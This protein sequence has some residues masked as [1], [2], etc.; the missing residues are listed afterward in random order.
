MDHQA[1]RGNSSG[2]G[3]LPGTM[4]FGVAHLSR[5]DMS[6]ALIIILWDHTVYPPWF[7]AIFL[8]YGL[9]IRRQHYYLLYN[10]QARNLRNVWR[11]IWLFRSLTCKY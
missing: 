11:N 8:L 10:P 3:E 9:Q 6:F 2:G 5:L 4:G 1:E 7:C